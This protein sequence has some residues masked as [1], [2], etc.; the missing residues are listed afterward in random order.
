M[1][2]LHPID[3]DVEG[4][5]KPIAYTA[6]DGT[7]SLTTIKQGDG[8]PLGQYAIT[9]ELRTQTIGEEVVRNGPNLL[10]PKFAHPKTSMLR[11]AVNEGTNK[12]P[13]ID[14]E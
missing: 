3:G 9:V 4:I 10:P 11:F 6:A 12:I 1:V 8:A 2:V 7:F 13:T 14:L 5:Q